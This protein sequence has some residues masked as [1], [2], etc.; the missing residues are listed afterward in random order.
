MTNFSS[1]PRPTAM[2]DRD[3][4]LA[5]LHQQ[6][7][8]NREKFLNLELDLAAT[9]CGMAERH[10]KNPERRAELERKI[11]DAIDTVHHLAGRIEDRSIREAILERAE[12]LECRAGTLTAQRE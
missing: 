5:D 1:L 11:Q 7:Q 12:E 9:L 8:R 4:S 6:I 3:I 2:A 10:R